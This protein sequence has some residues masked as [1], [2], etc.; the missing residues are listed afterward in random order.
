MNLSMVK[1]RKSRSDGKSRQANRKPTKPRLRLEALE[2]REVMSVTFHGGAV[3]PSVDVENVYLGSDWIDGNSFPVPQVDALD[4]FTQTLVSSQYMD[5]LS[6]AGYAVGEGSY[7]LHQLMPE[8]IDK[9]QMLTENSIAWSLQHEIWDKLI[10]PPTDNMLYVVYV[11][12]GVV[13]QDNSGRDSS[14][15]FYGFHNAFGGS[16]IVDDVQVPADIRYVVVPYPGSGNQAV[17]W[18][19]PQDQLTDVASQQI[20]NAITDPDANYFRMYTAFGLGGTP[21]SHSKG[22]YDDGL[23]QEVGDITNLQTVYENGSV[24]QRIADKNDQPMTPSDATSQRPVTFL[25]SKPNRLFGSVLSVRTDDGATTAVAGSVR[26][27][28]DQGI[29]NQ[30]R[31]MIDVILNDGSLYEYHD[32]TGLIRLQSP[33]VTTNVLDAKAGQ[34]ESFVLL[35]DHTAWRYN[36][37]TGAWR[38]IDN[39]VNAIDVGTDRY[40]VNDMVESYGSG[41]AIWEWSDSTGW[42]YITSNISQFSAGRQGNVG[43][44][45]YGTAGWWNEQNPGQI[46]WIDYS[47]RSVS[48]GYNPDG[49]PVF[50]MLRTNNDLDVYV[51]YQGSWSMFYKA[52]WN[53]RS[54]SK[55]RAGIFN[56]VSY[57]NN[58]YQF[59]ASQ[60]FYHYWPDWGVSNT[61]QAA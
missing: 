23:N 15:D 50:E 42:H 59:D 24:V 8:S 26:S 56:T 39:N 51:F 20:A 14:K 54:M 30:G 33:Y 40:G 31:A 7:E 34:G 35:N 6:K 60:I 44:V 32:G 3:L 29:D 10:P 27:I 43:L 21:G 5:T 19:S 61:I 18:L 38:W 45:Y 47:V 2:S 49:T 12:S 22:W 25:V 55:A 1:P 48:V 37:Q 53:V 41:R 36:D 46:N 4:N 17:P 52:D 28:S 9:S 57:Y 11:E 16:K 58:A 13:V